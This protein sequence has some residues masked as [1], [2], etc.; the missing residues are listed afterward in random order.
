[1]AIVTL[2]FGY[3]AME[4]VAA[5]VAMAPTSVG[6][7]LKL[8]MEARQLD[9]DFGQTIIA[10]AF[11]DDILSLILFLMLFSLGTTGEFDVMTLVVKP[12][13][14]I[15]FLCF[16][17]YLG[18]KVF[19]HRMDQFLHWLDDRLKPPR[20]GEFSQTQECHLG[21]MVALLLL[22]AVITWWL[23]SHLWGCFV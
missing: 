5:G 9:Q 10:A 17:A 1:M 15:I 4:G 2:G 8:L 18:A 6:I 13:L 21:L 16:G 20:E 3:S 23:G 19:P 14:A 22:Y 7:A 12:T 11:L